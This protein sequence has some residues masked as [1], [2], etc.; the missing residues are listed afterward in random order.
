MLLSAN[1]RLS[2]CLLFTQDYIHQIRMLSHV[3]GCCIVQNEKKQCHVF[4][5]V[6]GNKKKCNSVKQENQLYVIKCDLFWWMAQRVRPLTVWIMS[7]LKSFRMRRL[8]GSHSPPTGGD[9]GVLASLL[10]IKLVTLVYIQQLYCL[11][12]RSIC[13]CDCMFVFLW[14]TFHYFRLVQIL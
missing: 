8:C 10:R 2:Y 9:W 14:P 3:T 4:A 5:N 11:Y 6:G 7:Y 13:L 12:F 1:V